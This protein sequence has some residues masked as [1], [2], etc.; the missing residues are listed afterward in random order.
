MS[1]EDLSLRRA[2]QEDGAIL[3]EWR[4]DPLVRRNSLNTKEVTAKEHQS[5]LCAKLASANVRLYIVC[6][7]DKPAGQVR[8]DRS[9]SYAEISYGLAAEYRGLGLGR[10]VLELLEEEALLMGGIAE[11]YALVR[12]E[13]KASAKCFE[14][15]DYMKLEER[16]GIITYK[17]ELG[18]NYVLH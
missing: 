5:W 9:G 4:N 1:R 12:A 18:Q 11:L 8:L 7:G 10:K 13:N 6:A 14:A 17:K 2:E 15:L 16:G 3:L